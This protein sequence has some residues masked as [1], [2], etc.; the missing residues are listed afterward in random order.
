VSRARILAGIRAGRPLQGPAEVHVDITNGCNA[1]C[2]TC[3]DHSPLLD[4]PRPA[5]WKRRRLSL[6]RFQALC[7]ELAALG[8]VRA[9][10]LSGMGDPLTHPDAP[11]MM[12]RVRREGW[13][14]TVLSNLL[15]ADMDALCRP[16]AEGPAQ[17]APLVDSLLVGVH[18]ATPD[19]YAAFH[20]GWGAEH[21]TELTRR[22]RRLQRA[23][24]PVRHV[25][26]ID[27]HTA[28]ELVEMVDFAHLFGA[29]RVNYKLASLSE[30]TEA[31]AVSPAQR[32]WLAEQAI[33]AARAR[34]SALGVRTNLDLFAAQVS[35]SEAGTET[36][37]MA[38]VGCYMGF[39]YT[40]ITVDLDV[41]Y[42]CN[43]AAR[44]GSLRET[45]FAALWEGEA[46]QALRDRLGA[47]DF[48]PGCERCGKFEQN[49]AWAARVAAA[50]PPVAP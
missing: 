26:V 12:A 35:A 46:W 8:S 16:V 48:L 36:T 49:V 14:L 2:I 3:W 50:R 9:F 20:P 31:T 24:V 17:G 22:L 32:R 33:P 27:R 40:R 37:D 39:V 4:R 18:G 10:V 5:E 6:P 34:A 7:D 15:G 42:C 28:P 13:R 1:A 11:A 44:V 21:F 43:T 45:P 25:Q 19:V 30:G 23:G 41:L 38:A 47:G 29:E